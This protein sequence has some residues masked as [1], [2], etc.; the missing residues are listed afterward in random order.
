MTPSPRQVELTTEDGRVPCWIHR[1]ADAAAAPLP[2]VLFYPDAGSVRPAM[3]EMAARVAAMGHVVLMPHIFYR[4]GD[5]PPFDLKTVFT[6]PEERERLMKLVRSLDIASAMRDAGH[7]LRALHAEAGVRPGPIGTMGYCIGGRLAF[8]TSIHHPEAIAAAAVI[9]G[10]GI[11][12]QAEDSLHLQAA[13]IQARLYFGIAD[14]D[15]SC[16]PEQQALLVQALAAVHVRFTLDHFA[17]ALHGFAVSDFPVYQEAAATT[18]WRRITELFQT[19]LA[20]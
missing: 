18:H 14:N 2:G 10:G 9:H 19:A 3:H 4:H 5:Y 15:P 1:P 8:A 20:A 11:A 12:T 7:Y 13:R 17:G 16:T 6:V